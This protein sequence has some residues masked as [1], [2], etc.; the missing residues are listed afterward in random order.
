MANGIVELFANQRAA[1]KDE[2][3]VKGLAV[4]GRLADDHYAPAPG[5]DGFR[6]QVAVQGERWLDRRKGGYAMVQK[7]AIQGVFSLGSL[8]GDL[9]TWAVVR[10]PLATLVSWTTVDAGVAQRGRSAAVDRILPDV[11][12]QL[13]QI[14]DIADRQVALIH[15][16][17]Q[18]LADHLPRERV[19]RYEDIVATGGVSLSA[20]V[21]AAAGL[22]A[23]LESRNLNPIY[24]PKT[25]MKLGEK[26]L[27]SEGAAW[28][29]H[30]KAE[31]DALLCDVAFFLGYSR[32]PRFS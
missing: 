30:R 8:P 14:P 29:F 1:V 19:I 4:D 5:P 28:S 21:P 9:E 11:G 3:K 31:V 2:G 32:M 12:N 27:D 10:N 16:V 6:P 13:E 20:M 15:R 17:Y 26:L 22:S 23:A 24:E 18:Q 25:M 7:Q